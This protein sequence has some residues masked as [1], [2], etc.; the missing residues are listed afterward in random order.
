MSLAS[1]PPRQALEFGPRPDPSS[2]IFETL[3]VSDGTAVELDE[4]LS[5]LAASAAEL[6]SVTLPSDLRSR[7]AT[8]ASGHN[9]RFRV[10][11]SALGVVEFDRAPMVPSRDYGSVAPFVLPGGLGSHKWIDRRLLEALA[12]AAGDGAVALILD[13]S[14]A[15]LETTWANVLIEERGELVS[16]PHDGRFRSGVGCRRHAFREE[17]VDL[18]R[19]L[20]ADAVLLTSALRTVRLG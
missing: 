19:L 4:H 16:P 2:G 5:R 20:A 8:A 13:S 6:Y 1:L 15:V 12:D 14:G 3:R 18:D 7:I 17:P 11:L 9:G 10:S